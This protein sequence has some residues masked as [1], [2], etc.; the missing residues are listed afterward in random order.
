MVNMDVVVFCD[1]EE[2][3]EDEIPWIGRVVKLH[4]EVKE[5]NVQWFEVSRLLSNFL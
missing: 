4:P 5:F 1:R 2:A 3:I